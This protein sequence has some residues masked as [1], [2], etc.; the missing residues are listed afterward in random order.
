MHFTN[1]VNHACVEKHALSKSG[2]TSVNVRTDPDV[3]GALKR[4][5][6][7]GGISGHGIDGE[8]WGNSTT[9]MD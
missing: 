8:Y 1:P 5:G 9:E 2:L 7:F 4:N 3:A 6:T